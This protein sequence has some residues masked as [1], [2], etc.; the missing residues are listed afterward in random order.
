[1]NKCKDNIAVFR[2][3][4][5]IRLT[6]SINEHY[7]WNLGS[8]DLY[9]YM[10]NIPDSWMLKEQELSDAGIQIGSHPRMVDA[11]WD[12]GNQ[13]SRPSVP[14]N[15]LLVLNITFSGDFL[16]SLIIELPPF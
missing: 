7:L 6:K 10:L 13:W 4:D 14:N 12:N 8:Q 15:A 1:M 5:K 11:V 2:D 9:I 3:F 16:C